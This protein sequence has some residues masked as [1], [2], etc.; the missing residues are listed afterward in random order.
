MTCGEP[1]GLYG[2]RKSPPKKALRNFP[3]RREP[4]AESCPAAVGPLPD[5]TTER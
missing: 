5:R 2:T 3:G 1:E 4:F